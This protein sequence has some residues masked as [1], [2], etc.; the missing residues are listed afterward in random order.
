[1]SYRPRRSLN[2]SKAS[3]VIVAAVGIDDDGTEGVIDVVNVVVVVGCEAVANLWG[4]A[5]GGGDETL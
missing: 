5:P 4:F 3:S 1:M 2:C